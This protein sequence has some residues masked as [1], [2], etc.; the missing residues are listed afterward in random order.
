VRV[1]GAIALPAAYL[2]SV[3]VSGMLF[4]AAFAIYAVRYWP[5]LTRPRVD[6]N[7]G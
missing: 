5:I 3:I 6:G 1:A 7:P 2:A 4:A